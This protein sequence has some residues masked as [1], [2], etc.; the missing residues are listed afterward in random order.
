MKN[1]IL[2][3]I[4]KYG[5][6]ILDFQIDLILE[7]YRILIEY[8]KMYHI[9]LTKITDENDFVI[10]NVID[11]LLL[12]EFISINDN[13]IIDLG[14]GNGI[15]GIFLAI[16]YPQ[17]K[18]TLVDS[19][20]K[21]IDF[22]NYVIKN[23]YLKNCETVSERIEVLPRSVKYREQFDIVVGRGLASMRELAELAAPYIKK[24]GSLICQKSYMVEEELQTAKQTID[25]C[26]LSLKSR[27]DYYIENNFRIILKYTK[28]TQISNLLPRH[29]G[30]YK[31]KLKF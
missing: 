31:K 2:T 11:T 15:P 26:G 13:N 12:N 10:K 21:K 19:T 6:S 29:I 16:F 25:F 18:I 5:F 4:N 22:V 30:E 3:F 7:Y 20:K 8:Q 17:N 23:L 28:T 24:G 14:T 1:I 27:K 9:N